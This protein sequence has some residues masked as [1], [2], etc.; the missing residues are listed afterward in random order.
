MSIEGGPFVCSIDG[1]TADAKDIEAKNEHCKKY[2]KEHRHTMRGTTVCRECGAELRYRGH[3]YIPLVVETGHLKHETMLYCD[4]CDGDTL[5]PRGVQI[6]V[7]TGEVV[8]HK[9]TQKT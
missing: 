3:P 6:E 7:M 2:G 4:K 8:E 5:N 1:F 9:D